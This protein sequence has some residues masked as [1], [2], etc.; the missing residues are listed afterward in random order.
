[1]YLFA[2]LRFLAHQEGRGV[3]GGCGTRRFQSSSLH[4]ATLIRII[5][6]IPCLC[7]C[8]GGTKHMHAVHVTIIAF[9]C[10]VERPRGNQ[11]SVCAVSPR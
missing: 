9:E 6:Y 3:V 2:R 7:R 1:M 11:L 5:M 4:R 8:F 10:T